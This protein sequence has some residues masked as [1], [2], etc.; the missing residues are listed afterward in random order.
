MYKPRSAAPIQKLQSA[1]VAGLIT[2]ILFW[3]LHTYAGVDLPAEVSSAI[4]TLI[5][6][7]IGY[8]TPFLPGEVVPVAAPQPPQ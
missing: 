4:T 2:T 5:A 1:F 3:V 8:V 7:L 6:L